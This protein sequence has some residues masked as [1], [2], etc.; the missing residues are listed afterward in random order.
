[1]KNLNYCFKDFVPYVLYFNLRF[2][3][4][5]PI[6]QMMDVQIFCDTISYSIKRLNVDFFMNKNSDSV[7]HLFLT[8]LDIVIK[9]LPGNYFFLESFI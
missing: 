3:F 5:F 1:M 6:F 8:H 9:I 7:I 4:S 2:R